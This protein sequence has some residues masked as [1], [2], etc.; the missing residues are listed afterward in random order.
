MEVVRKV[1]E[2]QILTDTDEQQ[3]NTAAGGVP[4]F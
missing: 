1:R 2:S 4:V 3:Y